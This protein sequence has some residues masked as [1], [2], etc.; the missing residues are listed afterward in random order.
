MSTAARSRP[1][2]AAPTNPQMTFQRICAISG[3]LCPLMFFGAFIAAGFI[4]PLAPSMSASEVAAYFQQHANGIRLGAGIMLLSGMFYAA[5]TAVLSGQMQRI[6]GVH[7]TVVFTQLAA[8]AFACLTFLVPALFFAVTA[9]RP[10]RSP[11]LTLLLDDLSWICL[12]MPWPP[13]MVQNFAFAF[14][15]FSDKGPQPL[16][17]RWLAYLNIWAPIVFTPGIVLQFFK[18]GPFAWNGIFVFWIPATVFVI[19]FVCNVIWLLR[20]IKAEQA[21]SQVA[22][23]LP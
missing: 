17:P 1:D 10:E 7:P 19:Q 13:F 4:P 2:G 6:R 9:F 5:Y 18:S 8:G 12:V 16:F 3:I 23:P 20:A 11:E 15:I 22:G 14:A 21:E